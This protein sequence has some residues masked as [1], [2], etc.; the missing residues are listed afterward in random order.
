[1][2]VHLRI[3]VIDKHGIMQFFSTAAE[4]LFGY[5]EHE[6]IGQNVSM[7]M[8]EPDRA[9]TTATS[10]AIDPPESGTSSASAGS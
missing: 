5:S 6:A 1:M 10:R 2:T 9:A 3:A 7:L 8:P 4:R